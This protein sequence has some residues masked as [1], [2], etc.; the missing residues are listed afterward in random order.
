MKRT[1][2]LDKE[3]YQK[4]YLSIK[5]VIMLLT[6]IVTSTGFYGLAQDTTLNL[7]VKSKT[8]GEVLNQLEHKTGYSFLVRSSDVDLKELVTI[9]AEKKSLSEVLTI[10][11]KNKNIKFEITGKSVSIFKPHKNQEATPVV[12][13]ISNKKFSGL[14]LDERGFPV[15][16]ASVIVPG[17]TIGV[18]SDLE[19]RFNLEAPLNAKIR[20][21][22]IGYVSKEEWVNDNTYFIVTLEPIPKALDEVIITA[23][24]IG[25]K[26]AISQQ[27]LSNTQIGRASWRVRV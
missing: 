16:G 24:A 19:G 7:Q 15:I 10:L 8:L 9:N 14:V 21:S 12:P 17:T 4:S 11:F 18:A 2:T 5:I 27:I 3:Y 25:Q 13:I 23:Q 26:Q 20:I 1:N 6:F 22:Y